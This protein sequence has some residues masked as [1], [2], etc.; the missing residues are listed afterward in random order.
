MV[1]IDRMAILTGHGYF[2]DSFAFFEFLPADVALRFIAAVCHWAAVSA[3]LAQ[4]HADHSGGLG[5]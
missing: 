2:E 3:V 1:G 5:T 4:G